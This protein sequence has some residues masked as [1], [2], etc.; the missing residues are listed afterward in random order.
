VAKTTK[1]QTAL[2]TSIYSLIRLAYR[3]YFCY[4][5]LYEEAI[6]MLAIRLDPELEQSL[7]TL[8]K[9]SGKNRS[10]IVRE[11]LLRYFEDMEDTALAEASYREMKT[12]KPLAE[13]RRELGLDS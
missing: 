10:A 13:L 8:V 2:V 3:L 9:S 12:A 5:L 1:S 6:I 4:T 11:A 7:D